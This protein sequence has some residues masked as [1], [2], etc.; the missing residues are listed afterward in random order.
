VLFV[1]IYRPGITVAIAGPW[2]RGNL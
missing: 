2:A 1:N